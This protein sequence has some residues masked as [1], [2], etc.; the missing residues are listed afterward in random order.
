MGE[1]DHGA[2]R[3]DDVPGF[4]RENDFTAL[5]RYEVADRLE[6]RGLVVLPTGS[7]EQ[8]G[9]H[10]PVGTDTYAVRD[11]ARRVAARLDGLYV[12]FSAFGVTP[13]HSD[14]AGAV[15]LSE[16]TM[17]ALFEDVCGSLIEHG[18]EEVVVVNWHEGNT[19]AL[20]TAAGRLQREHRDVRFVFS[21][22]NYAAQELYGDRHDLTHG[23]PLEVLPVLGTRPDLVHLD[24]ADDPSEEEHASMMDDLRRNRRAYPV[25]PDVRIMYPTGWYG[26]LDVVD[27][28][29]PETFLEEVAAD[30]AEDVAETLDILGDLEYRIAEGK[31]EESAPGDADD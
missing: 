23:G 27:E 30:C 1:T 28:V 16:E 11:I 6:E 2:G 26:D 24:R 22:A 9:G 7:V 15:D 3:Y 17:M 4:D 18:A 25:I 29:D 31:E 21:H 5:T 13:F 20:E 14:M 12:P 19:S 10:L 8:H